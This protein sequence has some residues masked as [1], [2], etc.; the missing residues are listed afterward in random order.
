MKVTKKQ[1]TLSILLVL[2]LLLALSVSVT[3]CRGNN[4]GDEAAEVPS[5]NVSYIFTNHQTPFVAA[6]Y[7]GEEF[8][9][10]GTYLKDRAKRKYE[11]HSDGKHVC[12]INVI[13]KS[14]SKQHL[15]RN[16]HVDMVWHQ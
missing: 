1:G 5:L 6:M 4:A 15:V 10:S 13:T 2:V 16:R 12:N 11:L 9:D 7:K 14:G 8:K 3:G